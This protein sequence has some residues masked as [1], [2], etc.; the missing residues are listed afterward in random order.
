MIKLPDI[1]WFQGLMQ[2]H[3]KGNTYIGS[4]GTDPSTGLM[5]QNILNYRVWIEEK[6]E[7]NELL[8][9]CYK[10]LKCF[11]ETADEDKITMSFPCSNDGVSQAKEWIEQIYTEGKI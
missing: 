1:F 3:G 5:K 6:E 10:G 7:G 4:I 8:A 11:E 9:I 2:F